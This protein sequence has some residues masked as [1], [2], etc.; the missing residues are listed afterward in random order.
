[1]QLFTLEFNNQ[2]IKVIGSNIT[3]KESLFIDDVQVLETRSFGMSNTYE[4]NLN[5]IGICFLTFSIKLADNFV[6]IQILSADKS[7]VLHESNQ[8]LSISSG[9][10]SNQQAGEK[11]GKLSNKLLS[12][13][14][15]GLILKFSKSFK[16]I[17]IMLLA[18]SAAV[19]SILFSW[20]FALILIAIL[21]F[22]EFGHVFAMKRSGLKTKGFYFIPFVGGMAVS[23]RAKSQW[24]EVF[25]SMMGPVFGLLMSLV[26]YILYLYTNNHFIGLVAA[27]SALINMFNLLPVYPLDGG[28]VMKAIVFSL[29]R[30][31]GFVVLLTLSAA[32]FAL[33]Y[34]AGWYFINFFIVIGFLDLVFSWKRFSTQPIEPLNKYGMIFSL[35][36]YFI[37]MAIFSGIIILMVNSG[38]PGTELIT[39]I[40]SS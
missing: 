30:Y 5:E 15:I 27:F 12:A 1:M 25:I 40:L 39:G 29:Q 35:I 10:P 22:H 34:V 2:I 38:L 20:Q 14:I 4:M 19:Y 32:G 17:K 36:W 9:Q 3:G 37:T 28:H 23:E 33:A 7:E 8:N 16:V 13:P 21:I 24:Q 11:P 6:T 18:S 26:F 31:W